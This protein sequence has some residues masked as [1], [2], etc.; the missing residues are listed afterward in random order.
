MDELSVMGRQKREQKNDEF[1][2]VVNRNRKL[3]ADQLQHQ[4]Y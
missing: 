4:G 2:E 1:D 3:D